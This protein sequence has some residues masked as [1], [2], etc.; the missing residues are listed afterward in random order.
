MRNNEE[1]VNQQCSAVQCWTVQ[2]AG[3][4]S[5]LLLRTYYVLI[6]ANAAAAAAAAAVQ[7]AGA[8]SADDLRQKQDCWR[9]SALMAF[10]CCHY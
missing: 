4:T 5:R 6:T 9:L 8:L 1:M 2:A 7:A 3:C 10:V